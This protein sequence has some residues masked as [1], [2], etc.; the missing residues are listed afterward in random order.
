MGNKSK[1]HIMELQ[2]TKRVYLTENKNL[3]M[4]STV[5]VFST[6]LF[7]FAYL[8][9]D[10]FCSIMNVATYLT[11]HSIFELMSIVVSFAVFAVSYFTYDQ[12]GNVKSAFLGSI[13]LSI[14]IIDMFHTLSFKGMPDFF[15]PIESANLATTFWIIG[16]LVMAA[17]LLV[18]AL[19]PER[20]GIE[21]NKWFFSI[22]PIVFSIAV[23]IIVVNFPDVLPPMYLESEGGLTGIKIAL[24]YLVIIMLAAT[25]TIILLRYHKEYSKE[26]DKNSAILFCCALIITIFS[27][28]A[29]VSYSEVYDIYNYLGHVYKIIAYFIIFRVIFISSVQK[30]YYEL[31]KARNELQNYAENLDRLV[32]QKTVQLRKVNQKLLEDLA[33]ARDIQRSLLPQYLPKDEE[34][35]FSAGYFPAERVSGDFY[36]VFK[37]DERSIGMYIGDVSGHGVPAAMLTVFAKQSIESCNEGENARDKIYS[38]ADVLD[39]VF[40]AFNNMNFRDDVYFIMLYAIYDKKTRTLTYASAGINAIPLIIR[41]DGSVEEMPVRGLP[42]CKISDIFTVKY[43]NNVITLQKGD[44]VIFYTDGL[45]EAHNFATERYSNEHLKKVLKENSGKS[46]SEL[47]KTIIKDIFDFTAPSSLTDDITFVIMEVL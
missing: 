23:L 10:W 15:R 4:L 34:V 7:K 38:P 13:Y 17:G 35:A 20:T 40:H 22:P 1:G 33:Y 24:E 12:T 32:E 29:F 28:L 27:E 6:L 19:I 5:F 30:P 43:E 44:K 2:R 26:Y 45:I 14:G 25:I 16:R 3:I 31:A 47:S 42:I 18:T 41:Q 8:L 39:N 46:A 37:I 36:S 21:I 9:E 11:W